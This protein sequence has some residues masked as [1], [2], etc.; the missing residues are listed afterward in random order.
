MTALHSDEYRRVVEALVAARKAAGLSQYELAAR[1][2]VE[3]SYVAK[4]ETVR[5]RLD[6]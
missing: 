3:Q 6:D 5:R 1:L 4:I 2:G